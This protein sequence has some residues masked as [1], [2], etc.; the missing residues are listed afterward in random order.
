MS[1]AFTGNV[2]RVFLGA[3]LHGGVEDSDAINLVNLATTTR[4]KL[5]LYLSTTFQA[6]FDEATLADLLTT[7][8][9]LNS[10]AGLSIYNGSGYTSK[11]ILVVAPTADNTL[12]R[13]VFTPGSPNYPW[14]SLGAP[15]GGFRYLRYL[16]VTVTPTGG[17]GFGTKLPI[18]AYDGGDVNGK[19]LVAGGDVN[20]SLPQVL[21]INM[22]GV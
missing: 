8:G 5:D 7:T 6:V 1:F 17:T 15:T 3:G 18:F 16:V 20:V 12:N 13:V 21:A 22:L 10:V 9:G 14:T 11:D 4:L 2:R 19:D